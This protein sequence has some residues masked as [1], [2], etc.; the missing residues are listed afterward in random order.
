MRDGFNSEA[1]Q[2]KDRHAGGKA[3]A[4]EG[5][6]GQYRSRNGPKEVLRIARI[7]VLEMNE[8]QGKCRWHRKRSLST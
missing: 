6:T 4:T 8:K 3:N 2:Q 1:E 5:E 7:R